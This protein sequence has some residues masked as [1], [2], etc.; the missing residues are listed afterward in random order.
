M[1]T[2]TFNGPIGSGLRARLV[3][4]LAN[5]QVKLGRK[6]LIASRHKEICLQLQELIPGSKITSAQA[7]FSVYAKYVEYD[8][9]TLIILDG[10]YEFFKGYVNKLPCEVWWVNN[11]TI[12]EVAPNCMHYGFTGVDTTYDELGEG[13]SDANS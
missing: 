8:E 7:L 11:N 5:E 4:T 3:A 12:V 1:I 2:K 6:V 9:N 13:E 10:R